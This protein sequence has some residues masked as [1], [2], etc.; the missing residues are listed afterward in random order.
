M[1]GSSNPDAG[2]DENNCIKQ[3]YLKGVE[4]FNTIGGSQRTYLYIWG[5]SSMKEGSKKPQEKKN[6]RHNK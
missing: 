2:G 6:L 5:Q 4:Y 1:M 3:R